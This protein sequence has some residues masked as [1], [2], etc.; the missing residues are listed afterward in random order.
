VIESCLYR[1]TQVLATNLLPIV[2]PNTYP[3]IPQILELIVVTLVHA[4]SLPLRTWECF[5]VNLSFHIVPITTEITMDQTSMVTISNLGFY[6]PAYSPN[7]LGLKG[8][9]NPWLMMPNP[10]Y[11]RWTSYI[12]PFPY[13]DI[14]LCFPNLVPIGITMMERSDRAKTLAHLPI[15][16]LVV[17][18]LK[19]KCH[20]PKLL[21]GMYFQGMV[22]LEVGY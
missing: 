11:L 13:T 20:F 19:I 14:V 8:M 22:T 12:P 10:C 1:S 3:I 15:L 4:T 5:G 17:S 9:T 16:L 2:I 21:H 6:P 18:L 7:L